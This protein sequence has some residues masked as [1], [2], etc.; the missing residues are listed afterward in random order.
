MAQQCCK[1]PRFASDRKPAIGQ[2]QIIWLH[3][4]FWLTQWAILEGGTLRVLIGCERF[5][6]V[7]QAFRAA[8]HD[9]W[10]CDLVADIDNS[11]HHLQ[12]DVLTV[13]DRD[14]DL[15]IFHPD[16]TYLTISAAWAF[17]DGPYHQKVKPGTLVGQARRDARSRAVEFVCKLRDAPIPCKAIENPR[18]FLSSIWR[19]PDQTIQPYEFGED[20]S[21]DTC[22]WLENLP[23]LVP[24]KVI[25]PRFVD[26]RP[27]WSNQTD[28]GQNKL[29]PRAAR[30]MQRASTYP[31]IASA[32]A[33]QWACY[34]QQKS[35]AQW[36][37][38][39]SR[40]WLALLD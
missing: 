28:S 17:L 18:G 29:T 27:R 12:C 39:V 40:D 3:Q 22:L 11:P 37:G 24:T 34:R 35:P 36:P 33:A 15:A 9:A 13:L 25:A 38:L 10:S 6:K 19:A 4:I 23:L 21:K 7:R 16:C 26:G 30:A 31:G 5:G 14:W 20:A 8:G 2:Q 32:F 1:S